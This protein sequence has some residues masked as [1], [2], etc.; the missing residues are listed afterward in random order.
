MEWSLLIS[1]SGFSLG[2]EAITG[3][4]NTSASPDDAEKMTETVRRILIT[5]KRHIT[6]E[7]DNQSPLLLNAPY[8]NAV[9]AEVHCRTLLEKLLEL[10]ALKPY[11]E[12]I[13]NL[14]KM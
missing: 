11:Y 12:E 1:R 3:L 13:H 14:L 2:M 7:K 4:I 10:P 8:P 9:P 6:A 5:A